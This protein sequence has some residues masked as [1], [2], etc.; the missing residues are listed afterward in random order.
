MAEASTFTE[1]GI[2]ES[3]LSWLDNVG[4]ERYKARQ[5]DIEIL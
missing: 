4:W 3:V 2:E 1:E 5:L